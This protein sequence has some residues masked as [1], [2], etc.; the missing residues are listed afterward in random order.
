MGLEDDQLLQVVRA[1]IVLTIVTRDITSNEAMEWPVSNVPVAAE[2]LQYCHH[3]DGLWICDDRRT[4]AR[5]P[6]PIQVDSFAGTK[7]TL[8][9]LKHVVDMSVLDNA[10]HS[11]TCTAVEFAVYASDKLFS[12]PAKAAES[13]IGQ[14]VNSPIIVAVVPNTTTGSIFRNST[15]MSY[16][17]KH[18]EMERFDVSSRT[19]RWYV[20]LDKSWSSDG[21]SVVY[22]KSDEDS[23]TCECEH[24]TSFA[25]LMDLSVDGSMASTH[26]HSGHQQALSIITYVGVGTSIVCLVVMITMFLIFNGAVNLSK[27]IQLH[28]AGTLIA[29]LVLFL[30]ATAG[31]TAGEATWCK[32]ARTLL[33]YS[34]LSS[35]CWCAV[36]ASHLYRTF[37]VV[38]DSATDEKRRLR[39]FAAFAYGVPAIIAGLTVLVVDD[40]DGTPSSWLSGDAIWAFAGPVLLVIV[41]N[42][43]VFAKI[44]VIIRT[45]R[46][47]SSA[48]R[49]SRLKRN[50]KATLSFFS[51]LGVTWIFGLLSLIESEDGNLVYQHAFSV[52]NAFTGVLMFA[53]HCWLDPGLREELATGSGTRN[54]RM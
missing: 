4:G 50:L 2:G 43:F 30:I 36:Q 45:V 6:R 53:Y 19:C 42:L 35:F 25:V 3:Q 54:A 14:T 12:S 40:S 48:S 34:L 47:N 16:T 9:P 18:A 41:G 21:C 52:L 22:G 7:I 13:F 44:M 8:P 24:L 15:K 38:F 31:F 51:L 32:T 37:V 1:N 26:D 20:E 23:T 39:L 28:L 49:W 10:N 27:K 5:P 33:H 29:S 46:E 17:V 11:T